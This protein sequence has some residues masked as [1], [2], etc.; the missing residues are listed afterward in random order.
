[1]QPQKCAWVWAIQSSVSN[2]QREAQASAVL[3]HREFGHEHCRRLAS[4]GPV[5]PGDPLRDGKALTSAGEHHYRSAEATARQPGT[6]HV[7]IGSSQFHEQIN[8]GNGDLVII[9]LRGV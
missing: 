5:S 3:D 8:L 6:K 4:A 2:P 1:C 9:S 7:A